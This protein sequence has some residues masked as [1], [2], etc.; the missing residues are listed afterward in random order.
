M[1]WRGGGEA[2]NGHGHK[3]QQPDEH[4]DCRSFEEMC[5]RVKMLIVTLEMYLNVAHVRVVLQQDNPGV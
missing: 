1:R 5:P 2:R 3:G 4:I